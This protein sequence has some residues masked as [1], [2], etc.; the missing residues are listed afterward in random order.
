MNDLDHERDALGHQLERWNTW[1][2]TNRELVDS[3]GIPPDIQSEV[4]QAG[5]DEYLEDAGVDN[6]G[7]DELEEA[8]GQMW[9]HAEHAGLDAP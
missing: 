2:A 4:Y 3:L 9:H 5:L 1:C 8:L 6:D 7:D